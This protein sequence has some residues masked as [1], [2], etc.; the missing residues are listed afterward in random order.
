M[1]KTKK[2]P[3]A[4]KIASSLQIAEDEINS[5]LPVVHQQSMVPEIL[6]PEIIV[7]PSI[8]LS[9]DVSDDY[10]FARNNLHGLLEKGN[11][12]LEG[13]SD[14]ASDSDSPRTFEVAGNMLKVLFE[15]TRELMTLQKDIRDVQDKTKNPDSPSTINIAS[16]EQ[17]TNNTIVGTTQE[18]LDMLAAIKQKKID[19]QIEKET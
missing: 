6:S 5:L 13:I 12:L 18:M 16:A 15:G 7:E 17:V 11:K 1:A 19:N 4:Q 2:I 10:E 8:K 14:L 3:V 9:K